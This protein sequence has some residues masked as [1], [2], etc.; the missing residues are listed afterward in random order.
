MFLQQQK[1]RNM[2]SLAAPK[3]P[4]TTTTRTLNN[5]FHSRHW[6]LTR[7]VLLCFTPLYALLPLSLF[8]F[9]FF[10]FF[11]SLS[12]TPT[13]CPHTYSAAEPSN[14]PLQ[15]YHITACQGNFRLIATNTSIAR[16]LIIPSSSP[17]TSWT[18]LCF[19]V[20]AIASVL[21]LFVVVVFQRP[22]SI[23]LLNKTAGCVSSATRRLTGSFIL[24]CRH[25]NHFLLV[26]ASRWLIPSAHSHSHLLQRAAFLPD[27][28]SLI[29]SFFPFL[30]SPLLSSVC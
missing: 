23:I 5:T 1:R 4:T 10:C 19:P 14:W 18:P 29:L 30:C 20:V 12:T 26:P 17:K 25:G 9:L 6:C 22:R 15:R 27:C 24:P 13:D 7:V 11:I 2:H 21:C 16:F 3:A 28:L 8:Y